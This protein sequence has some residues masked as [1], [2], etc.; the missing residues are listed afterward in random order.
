MTE[1]KHTAIIAAKTMITP[2]VCRFELRDPD[3]RAMPP[4]SVGSHITVRTPN[5][6]ARSYSLTDSPRSRGHYAIS[7]ARQ[8]DG[9]GGSRSLVDD[10][11]VGDKIQISDP[12]NA[13][14]LKEADDY[15]LIAG[16]IGIT[17]IRAI[18]HELQAT[19]HKRLRLIYLSR[20]AAETAYIEEFQAS[21]PS[22][23]AV[24][25]LSRDL[26]RLDLWP[27]LS[28]PGDTHIYC[29]GSDALMREVKALTFHWNPSALHFEE[30]K[31]V[32]PALMGDTRFRVVWAPTAQK[33]EV[34]AR[35][36]L[37]DALRANGITVESSC[38]SGTCGACRIALLSGDAEHRD[39]VLRPKDRANFIMPCVSRARIGSTLEVGP[40]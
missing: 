25:Q 38:N 30:F 29:C 15:L 27:Y 24:L 32:S 31:G 39:L 23:E 21:D 17:A 7:V 40:S 5:G 36:S 20:H 34:D 1:M 33:I 13:F 2:G 3:G 19:G 37:L 11:R 4:F 16:G 26:G 18:W 14:P 12:R 35:T 22:P 8:E 10:T 9:R 6:M 28:E